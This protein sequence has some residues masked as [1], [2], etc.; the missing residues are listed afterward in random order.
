MSF[1]LDTDIGSAYLKNDPRV[2][3]Q[4]TMHNVADYRDVPGLSIVDWMA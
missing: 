4:V 3:A 2:R 1:L